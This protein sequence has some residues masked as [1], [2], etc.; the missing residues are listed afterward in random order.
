[1]NGWHGVLLH[2]VGRYQS[3]LHHFKGCPRITCHHHN[4]LVS[5][6]HLHSRMNSYQQSLVNYNNMLQYS[7]PN[8][9][10]RHYTSN[11]LGLL[12]YHCR[13]HLFIQNHQ[14]DYHQHL[15]SKHYCCL[16]QSLSVTPTLSK[17]PPYHHNKASKLYQI[18][19]NSIQ[20]HRNLN[21][22]Q[23]LAEI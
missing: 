3:I 17:H 12:T 21:Q 16:N 18:S 7:K 14:C 22:C 19:S 9:K 6:A 15:H 20:H 4:Q 2:R 8:I 13:H 10:H 1:M 23:S 11:S 5:N